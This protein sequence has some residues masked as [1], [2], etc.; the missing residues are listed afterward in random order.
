MAEEPSS[1]ANKP[2]GQRPLTGKQAAVWVVAVVAAAI[3]FVVYRSGS[4]GP[5]EE[6][7]FC[8][9]VARFSRAYT[10]ASGNEIQEK[11]LPDERGHTIQRDIVQWVGTIDRIETSIAGGAFVSIALPCKDPTTLRT[12]NNALSD[13]DDRTIIPERTAMYATLAWAHKGQSVIISGEILADE[14]GNAR[15]M[16]ATARGSMTEPEFLF[17]FSAIEAK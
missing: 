4:S 9:S 10:A 12:W 1:Q 6:Q 17:R 7:A 14:H 5:S 16:S 11:A 3:G 15:E 8:E 2:F 13:V